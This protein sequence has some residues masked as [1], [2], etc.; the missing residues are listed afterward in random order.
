MKGN[1][2][3]VISGLRAFFVD[4][5]A[6]FPNSHLLLT[7]VEFGNQPETMALLQPLDKVPIEYRAADESTALWDAVIYALR[8]EKSR[9]EPPIFCVIASD[10]EDTNSA[11]PKQ[12]QRDARA[13]IQVRQ[14]W[15]NWVFY[16][17]NLQKKRPSDAARAL[18]IESIDCPV[19][20]INE[21]FARI[22]SRMARDVKTLHNT[23]QSA[24]LLGGVDH[25]R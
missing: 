24:L 7:L 21:G 15:G 12:K 11:N 14:S 19:E 20:K 22:A 23:K 9:Y 17:L 16:V 8:Q 13:M 25:G 10:G 4:L 1:E 5:R 2:T 18:L 3:L 6:A